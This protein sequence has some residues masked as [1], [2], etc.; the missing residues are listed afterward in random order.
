MSMG[1]SFQKSPK[2]G[3]ASRG[4]AS[5]R[6]AAAFVCDVQCVHPELVEKLGDG[7]IGWS[8]AA[9]LSQIFQVMSDPT[10][11]RIISL[12][13]QG[14]L[15][16]CDIASA[17]NMTQSAVS[18]QLRVLRLAEL[19]R[20]RKEGRV[21]WYKL[22]DDHVLELLIQGI[23]HAAHTDTQGHVVH[24]R[25]SGPRSSTADRGPRKSVKDSRR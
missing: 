10:R 25:H 15:C 11:L 20:V 13:S 5:D 16:V 1:S 8:E 7:I 18:H 19:V 6:P 22:D 17:L 23:D 2:P 24:S 12:L 21:A 14:E 9:E 4:R 3:A